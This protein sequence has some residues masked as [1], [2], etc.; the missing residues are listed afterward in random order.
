M[1]SPPHAAL[2]APAY[3]PRRPLRALFVHRNFP[4]QYAHLAP[5]LAE[6]R[7]VQVWSLGEAEIARPPGVRHLH[8][9]A[10]AQASGGAHPFLRPFDE[11]VRRAHAAAGRLAEARDKEG[12]RPDV[13]L[14]HAGWGEALYLKDV[15]PDARTLHYCEFY[16]H[17]AGQDVGFDPARPVTLDEAA[18]VRTLN[19][20]PLLA[21]Q[22]ADWGVSPTEWQRSRYPGWARPR[23]SRI[24]DGIDTTRCAPR[25]DV[26]LRLPDGREFRRGD[27]VI[28]YAARSLE[29][30]R[31][32]PVFLEALAL[33]QRAH[34]DLQA[35]VVG[36]DDVSYGV[37]PPHA[38]TWREEV[39]AQ[40]EGRL[41]LG[42]IHFT[43]RLPH[44]ALHAL[45][46]VTAAH[47]YLTYPFV[48]SWSVL[49]AMACGAVVVG[50]D[51][52]PVAEVIAH[53][54]N[55][56]LAPFWDPAAIAA[57]VGG[58]LADPAG[59]AHL[60]AAARQSVVERFDLHTVCLPRQLD[61]V[62]RIAAGLDPEPE[63]AP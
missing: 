16:Y 26:R 7:G 47:V 32:F 58:V 2:A 25:A 19:A 39:L 28:S 52:P 15:F 4:A 23:I 24:H 63:S 22:S 50:S 12:L 20:T 41:D 1:T 17:A 34:P 9:G 36:S 8:Y 40:M 48:L 43:G 46:R 56:L 61:L 3:Q 42:R 11:A 62:E 6:R 5:T 54:E 45:F 30:Y 49:E 33:L 51:T 13:I 55:G 31:G 18:R 27:R 59:H 57:A 60:G 53:G 37:A 38:A 44:E 14:C 35:V 21:L 10:P 29:P